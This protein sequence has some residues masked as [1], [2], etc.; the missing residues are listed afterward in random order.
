MNPPEEFFWSSLQIN[1][2]SVSKRR[3]DKGNVGMSIIIGLGDY[4]G[5]ELSSDSL[6]EP[7]NIRNAALLFDGRIPHESYPFR[8]A[9]H[10]ISVVAYLHSSHDKVST[11]LY[12][13][14][15]AMGFRIP[16]PAVAPVWGGESN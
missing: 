8:A 10:R 2:D 9:T 11:G 15:C 16:P 4:E 13:R 7:A 1:V 6:Q 12:R 14:C 5:G 3:T